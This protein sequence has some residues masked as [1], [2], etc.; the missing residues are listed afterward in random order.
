MSTDQTKLKDKSKILKKIHDDL[1]YYKKISKPI[2]RQLDRIQRI[3]DPVLRYSLV[4]ETMTSI[5]DIGLSASLIAME[6][7]VE[8]KLE[9]IEVSLTSEEIQKIT[10]MKEGAISEMTLLR[11]GIEKFFGQLREWIS[12][13]VYSPDHPF[14]N[15]VMNDAKA[16]FSERAETIQKI[17]EF[18]EILLKTYADE[19]QKLVKLDASEMEEDTNRM[20]QKMETWKNF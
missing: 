12:Q 2:Q 8:D 5:I 16:E 3:K 9:N 13:P 1:S 14:G 4:V 11:D 15:K 7:T 19:R 6:N 20:K 10:T 18:Q 17:N